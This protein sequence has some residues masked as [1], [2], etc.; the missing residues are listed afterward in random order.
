MQA[1]PVI[2][3]VVA[4]WAVAVVVTVITW[5]AAGED[6]NPDSAVEL[7]LGMVLPGLLAVAIACAVVHLLNRRRADRGRP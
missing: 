4:V 3:A 7:V 1:R 2:L 5:L 6:R